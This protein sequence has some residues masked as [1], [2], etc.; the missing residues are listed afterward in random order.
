MTEIE[1]KTLVETQTIQLPSSGID[2]FPGHFLHLD[3][4]EIK[5]DGV[6]YWLRIKA[7]YQFEKK[8]S[9]W[10]KVDNFIIKYGYHYIIV[11]FLYQA[12]YVWNYLLEKYKIE[13]E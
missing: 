13:S 6:V 7:W 2:R 1:V 3:E 8:D 4:E 5:V 11:D 9:R 10:Q 12:I